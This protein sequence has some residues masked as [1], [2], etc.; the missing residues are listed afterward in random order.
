MKRIV[1]AL[2]IVAAVAVTTVLY[3]AHVRGKRN[4]EVKVTLAEC[5]AAVQETIAA[6]TVGAT[7]KEIEKEMEKGQVVYEAEFVLDGQE[8]EISVGE[9]GTLLGK[10]VEGDDEDEDGDDEGDDDE[11]EGEVQVTLAECPQAVQDTITA[12]T[13]GATI[14]EIEKEMKKGQVVYEAE[15]VL[16]GQEYEISVAADGKLLG[17]ELEDD[18]DDD[19]D[20][21][22]DD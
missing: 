6:E 11:D 13:V 21:N 17:K 8:Y 22:D 18:E 19:D 14:K 10:E 9:D 20:G 12:E 7:I 15:F 1:L 16:D 5:P 3:A 4:P 2:A